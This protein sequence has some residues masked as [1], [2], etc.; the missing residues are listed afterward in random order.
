MADGG[1]AVARALERLAPELAV[2]MPRRA[3]DINEL[4]DAIDSDIDG[5]AR[6]RRA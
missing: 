3:D 2:A 5:P 4:P 6:G 1:A